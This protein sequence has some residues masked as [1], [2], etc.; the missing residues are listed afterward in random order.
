MCT[1]Y[2]VY[3]WD[4][5][6]K[7]WQLRTWSRDNLCYLTF[8]SDTGQHSQ[9]LRCFK[10]SIVWVPN[11]VYSV[12]STP[13]ATKWFGLTWFGFGLFWIW[14]GLVWS[15]VSANVNLWQFKA[16]RSSR[17]KWL[18]FALLNN[19]LWS[20]N[21]LNGWFVKHYILIEFREAPGKGF[22]TLIFFLTQCPY[23]LLF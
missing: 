13:N 9:F 1:L 15:P 5:D 16:A 14:F 4:T 10:Q 12:L 22:L 18:S 3:I 2:S 6:Y 17:D 8:K 19:W 11:T 21:H 23:V 20:V 7:F